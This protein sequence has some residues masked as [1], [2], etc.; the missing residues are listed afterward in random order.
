MMKC[1]ISKGLRFNLAI[2]HIVHYMLY[3][4]IFFFN[5]SELFLIDYIGKGHVYYSPTISHN[6]SVLLCI[7]DI[8]FQYVCKIYVIGNILQCIHVY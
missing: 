4:L 5:E 3:V 7:T 2:R 1:L 8:G 6:D